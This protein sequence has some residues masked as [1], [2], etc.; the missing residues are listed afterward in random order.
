MMTI[1]R[2]CVASLLSFFAACGSPSAKQESSEPTPTPITEREFKDRVV[3]NTIQKVRHDRFNKFYFGTDGR[4]VQAGFAGLNNSLLSIQGGT[5]TFDG[6]TVC[7]EREWRDGGQDTGCLT[8]DVVGDGIRC[9]IKWNGQK[10]PH[11]FTCSIGEGRH[12]IIESALSRR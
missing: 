10:K 11:R 9:T 7:M 8:I 12:P 4:Y 3:G 5:Y 6:G 2:Y 1:R